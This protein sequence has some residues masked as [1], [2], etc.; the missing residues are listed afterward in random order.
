MRSAESTSSNPA[1]AEG[2][3]VVSVERFGVLPNGMDATPGVLAALEYC[4]ANGVR[5]LLF[6]SGRYDFHPDL[7]EDRYLHV[8][9]N[10]EGLKRVVFPLV[11]FRQF[12]ID[13]QDSTFVFHGLLNPFYISGSSSI[14]LKGFSVDFSRSFHSEGQILSTDEEGMD[15]HIDDRFPYEIRG[16]LLRFIGHETADKISTPTTKDNLYG[17][18]HLLEFD[19]AK[20]KTASMAEDTYLHG[21]TSYPARAI[22]ERKVRLLVPGLTGTRG[23]TMVFGPNHRNHPAFIFHKSHDICLDSVTIHHAGG[24][25][26]LAQLCDN[27]HIAGCRV[28]PSEG[29]IISTTADATHFVNCSGKIILTDNLF[30]NQQDDAA[31]IHGVYVQVTRII[32][33]HEILV[34]F[35]HPQQFGFDFIQ[36]GLEIEFVDAGSLKT[37]GEGKVVRKITLN[38]EF[39]NVVLKD[40][41]PGDLAVGDVIASGRYYPEVIITG[42]TIRNNRARG[43]LLN[44]RGKTHVANN[45]FHTPGAAILFEGDASHWFEQGGVRDC[46][47]EENTF[48]NCLFGIWGKAVIDVQAGIHADRESSRYNRNIVIRN[49]RFIRNNQRPLLH[50]F[51]VDNLRWLDNQVVESGDC[52]VVADPEKPFNISFCSNVSIGDDLYPQDG[53][54]PDKQL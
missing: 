42:N 19:T 49:N 2:P 31:N 25:G 13:A 26:V 17:S 48:E 39:T 54:S 4:R 7:G 9:N 50:A 20:R 14:T 52:P 22:G 53:S 12:T 45:Y 15:L 34:K 27:V 37:I 44:C 33:P 24:M 21:T 8:C 29:R 51:C 46:V 38:K 1:A 32:N 40:P 18:D 16:G 47:I 3:A 6:P 23:N 36:D 10:D 28:T 43:M 41:V 35:V 11:D 5:C 30:E